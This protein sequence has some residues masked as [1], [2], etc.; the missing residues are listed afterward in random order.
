[1]SN[2]ACCHSFLCSRSKKSRGKLQ[3]SLLS[4]TSPGPKASTPS[5]GYHSDSHEEEDTDSEEGPEVIED[6]ATLEDEG[7]VGL[8]HSK[9]KVL[10]NFVYELTW[11]V[12]SC[13]IQQYGNSVDFFDTS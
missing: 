5:L 13:S 12:L 6:L 8:S 2:L 1:M 10:G 4:S 11:V 7:V 9:Y 3:K